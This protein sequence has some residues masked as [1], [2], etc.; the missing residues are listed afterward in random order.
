MSPDAR[1][2]VDAMGGDEGLAVMLA[3]VA[4]ARRQYDGM[5]FLLVGDETKI[6]EGLSAH[7]N[8]TAASEIV[9]APD[10]I[11][12]S[13]KPSQ[14]I[15]RAKT[16]S[17]GVAIDLVKQGRAAAAVSSGNTGALM[18]MAKLSLR[19]LPGIDRPALAAMLP[20]LGDT[21]TVMLDLGANTECDARNLVQFAVMGAAWART[22]LD[23]D[24]PRVALLNIGTEA[25]KGTDEVREAAAALKSATHLP[26][27]FSGFIEGDRISR[28][29]VD[30]VVC[31]GFSG[32][33]ALKTAEGTA[34]FVGDLLKRAFR[35]SVRSK[36]GFLISKPATQL[37]RDHLDPNNHNGAVF[38]GLNGL[39]V[40]S[41]GG[42]TELGVAHAIG[43]A[44]KMVRD[45]LLNR[46]KSDLA[47]FEEQA[48]A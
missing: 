2:A 14:A 47:H 18:A 34:R 29:N 8:L 20:S 19:M 45:D 33:I 37:L 5:R 13:D 42:A 30:V 46:I 36:I 39:V 3:G 17:M 15:R 4:R 7:P 38:L 21:D 40:K 43:V 24:S 25:L 11:S 12:G 22:T 16:T 27:T 26:M 28:G 6:R 23:L 10:V 9:H 44:A 41:H 35:S 48:A 32:N 31:D 1:I